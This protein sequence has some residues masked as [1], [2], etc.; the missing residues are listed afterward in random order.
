MSPSKLVSGGLLAED[1]ACGADSVQHLIRRSK[2]DK[3]GRGMRV[4]LFSEN[5]PGICPVLAVEEFINV[6]LQVEGPLLLHRDGALLSKFQFVAI[7]R[8]CLPA[9]DFNLKE[10]SSYSFC[11]GAATEASHWG[12]DTGVIKCFG[13]WESDRYKLYVRPMLI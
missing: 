1:T 11:I 4:I 13:R 10:Y 6:R 8:K 2:T 7:F 9:S 3:R 5:C 12:L